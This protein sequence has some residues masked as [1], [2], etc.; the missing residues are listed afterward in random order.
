V[1]SAPSENQINI[2]DRESM[3]HLQPLTG[4]IAATYTPLTDDGDLNLSQVG[5]LVE[6]L[7][8]SQVD[9]LYVCGST[10]EGMSLSSDE[11]RALATES[12]N[13]AAG[14]VPVM[15]H[16]GHNSLREAASLARHAQELGARALSATCPSYYG[17]GSLEVLVDCAAEI[18]AAAPELPFYYYHIPALTRGDFNMSEF[19]QR[20]ADRIPNLAGL[21]YTKPTVHEFQQCLSDE[22]FDVLWG[23]DEMLLSAWVAGA[24]GAVGSTY[25]IAAPLY[26]RILQAAERGDLQE[27]ARLQAV[28]V[29]MI[30]TIG[31]FEFHPASKEVLKFLGVDCGNSRLPWK[32]LAPAEVSLLRQQLEAIG[33]F[34]FAV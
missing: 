22:R 24:R 27:A 7:L 33:F 11:R 30:S 20:A 3:P 23:V 5:P 17:I 1:T 25:N 6:H 9:G 10:G 21:K 34:D 8:A 26:Q 14:R 4:L 2:N 32:R 15:V 16:V 13:V 19:L 18:A 28:S 29:Q 31:Q 12:I